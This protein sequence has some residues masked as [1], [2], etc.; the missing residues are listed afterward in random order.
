MITLKD[1]Q[2]KSFVGFLQILY[3]FIPFYI[4]NDRAIIQS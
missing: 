1:W 3:H 2:C 4:Q